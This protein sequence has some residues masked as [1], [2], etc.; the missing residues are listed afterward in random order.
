MPKV[1][2]EKE[3]L[4]PIKSLYKTIADFKSYPDFLPEV[5]SVKVGEA[6]AER[7]LVEFEIEVMKQV[8]WKLVESNFFKTNDGKWLLK[9]IGPAKTH[10]T[11]EL[12]LNLGFF[13]PSWVSRKLTEVNLPAMFESYEKRAKTV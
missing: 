3:F 9:E 11:Y 12:D 6:T 13:V 2:R 8:Q 7:T 4:V 1:I 5:K 10:V